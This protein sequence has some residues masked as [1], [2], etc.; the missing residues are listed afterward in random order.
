MLIRENLFMG[1]FW[2][3]GGASLSDALRAQEKI[4]TERIRNVSDLQQLTEQF[5]DELI[6]DSLVNPLVL[7]FDRMTRKTRTEELD[8]SLSGS[9]FTMGQ[10][11]VTRTVVRISI[12]FEGDPPLFKMSPSTCRSSFPQGEVSGHTLQFDIMLWGGDGEE[13][14]AVKRLAE[15]RESLEFYVSNAN[16]QIKEF[17]EAIP[18]T[19]KAS[20]E[21]KLA[22]LT[23]QHS[24]FD[25]LG[26][27]EEKEI[28][29]P[30]VPAEPVKRNRKSPV[31][32]PQI[33]QYIGAQYVEQLTQI[34]NNVGGDVNNEIQSGQQ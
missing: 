20:F 33:I 26:I 21:Q 27:P 22:S 6:K 13:E 14:Q 29:T 4:I 3:R 31:P 16:K 7:K 25:S 9:R 30:F 11:S 17:N 15:N 24:I 8:P 5:L 32:P 1:G 12:P 18:A 10:T 23:K 28:Q 34:N 2:G 19:V